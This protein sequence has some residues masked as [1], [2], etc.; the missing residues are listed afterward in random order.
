MLWAKHVA[1]TA[2]A[3]RSSTVAS[4][5][6]KVDTEGA[7]G[8]GRREDSHEGNIRSHW[9]GEPRESSGRMRLTTR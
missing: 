2:M 4:V 1:M 7:C 6:R 3:P 8:C 9:D 5:S